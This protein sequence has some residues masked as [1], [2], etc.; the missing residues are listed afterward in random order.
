[1][2]D[3]E[4]KKAA[5]LSDVTSF[6][7]AA[8]GKEYEIAATLNALDDNAHGTDGLYL[9]VTGLSCE[10]GDSGQVGRGNRVNGL[11]SFLRPQTMEA[12]AGKN[13]KSHVGRIYSFAAQ[14]LARRLSEEIPEVKE[15]TVVLLGKIGSPVN[16]PAEVFADVK[17]WGHCHDD[18]A[19]HKAS[20]VLNAAIAEG[21]V[22]QRDHLVSAQRVTAERGRQ[23]RSSAARR[24][25]AS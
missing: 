17:M 12:W 19:Q 20:E 2:Q 1:V 16:R 4:F 22:F 13:A 24:E 11:I 23:Q 14:G 5:I 7:N 18:A 25:H 8:Y 9:T 6:V 10:G 21:A 3:Y 15:A